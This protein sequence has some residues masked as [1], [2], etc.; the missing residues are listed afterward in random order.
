MCRP[1]CELLLLQ[2]PAAAFGA[3]A[4]AA[5][6][7]TLPG[8]HVPLSDGQSPI[9]W[10]E[11]LDIDAEEYKLKPLK[12]R[13]FIDR[14]DADDAAALAKYLP[15]THDARVDV[16]N[17][18]AVDAAVAAAAAWKPSEEGEPTRL[19]FD[20]HAFHTAVIPVKKSTPATAM[21]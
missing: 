8:L 6:Q 10:I 12:H 16:S 17:A 18:A 13:K 19:S 21:A 5:S 9:Q 7:P 4:A 20:L 1:P 14:V 2:G 15:L 3:A 11:S